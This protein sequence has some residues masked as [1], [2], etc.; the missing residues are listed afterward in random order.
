MGNVSPSG[1]YFHDPAVIPAIYVQ[2]QHRLDTAVTACCPTPPTYLGKA[3][4]GQMSAMS[5]HHRSQCA[6]E[7]LPCPHLL[8]H[9]PDSRRSS[10]GTPGGPHRCAAGGVRTR[11]PPRRWCAHPETPPWRAKKA[12][13]PP[14]PRQTKIGRPAGRPGSKK[15]TTR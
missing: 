6:P 1:G 13:E 5:S 3:C 8:D 4:I 15:H 14:G 11:H 10:S 9:A 2:N 7:S 12:L